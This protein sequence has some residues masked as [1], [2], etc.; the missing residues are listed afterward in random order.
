MSRWDEYD[1]DDDGNPEWIGPVREEPDCPS[2]GDSGTVAPRG[3][4]RRLLRRSNCPSCSPT[5]FD[6]ASY[7]LRLRAQTLARAVRPRRRM[8]AFNDDPPF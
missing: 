2:C 8:N 7:V 5:R 1:F 6:M 4:L 3:L